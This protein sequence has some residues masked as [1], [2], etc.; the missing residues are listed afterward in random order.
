MTENRKRKQLARKRSRTTLQALVVRMKRHVEIL[1]RVAAT[2]KGDPADSFSH[3]A[4]VA[5]T[6]ARDAASGRVS[7]A[8]LEVLQKFV[9][10]QVKAAK[11]Y[12]EGCD[13]GEA[14]AEV[15]GEP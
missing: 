12:E 2:T 14:L 10:M 5:R 11:L 1:D 13:P 7:R 4:K 8:R 3:A 6:L 9:G 15:K